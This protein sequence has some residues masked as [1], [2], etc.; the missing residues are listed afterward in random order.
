LDQEALGSLA[1]FMREARLRSHHPDHA[2]RA[3]QNI[4]T[5]INVP[6]LLLATVQLLRVVEAQNITS[7]VF[8]SRD[9]EQWLELFRALRPDIATN[10][11]YSSRIARLHPSDDYRRYSH[12]LIKPGS[13]VVD[14]CGTGWSL[15]HLFASL[16]LQNQPVFLIHHVEKLAMYEAKRPTA[17]TQRIYTAMAPTRKLPNVAIELINTAEH[18]SALDI[19]FIAGAAVPVFAA[20]WPETIRT[21]IRTQRQAFA[22][23]VKL[24]PYHNIADIYALPP[25][26][27]SA[28]IQT[29]YEHLNT[30][31]VLREVFIGAYCEEARDV[32]GTLGLPPP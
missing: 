21:A 13:M 3:L 8:C 10:Y 17:D 26:R 25:A 29:L 4:Q 19:R 32:H 11:Y 15:S 31:P 2:L 9:C 22:D 24:L 14:I 7:L 23:T 16:G 12:D 27:I 30:Q 20:P 18:G 6:I 28:L 1:L 5:Q